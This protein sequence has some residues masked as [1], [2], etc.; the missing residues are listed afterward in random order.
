VARQ[1]QVVLV[2]RDVE[3]IGGAT[4]TED[5][6]QLELMERGHRFAKTVLNMPAR[7]SSR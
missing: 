4:R 1:W 3:A 2:G 5:I 7:S 6:S